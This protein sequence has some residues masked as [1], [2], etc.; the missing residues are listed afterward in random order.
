VF[1]SA[2]R[3]GFPRY[4]IDVLLDVVAL[5]SGIPNNMPGRCCDLSE[6]GLS[7][8]VAGELVAGQAVAIELR[9]PNVGLPV[10]ARAQVR[11]Q[12]R[13][14]CG[15]QFVGLSIEQREKIRYWTAQSGARLNPVEVRRVEIPTPELPVVATASESEKRQRK[16]RF[17]K[18]QFFLLLAVLATLGAVAWWQWQNAWSELEGEASASAETQPGQLLRVPSETMDRQITYKADPVYPDAARKTGTRG[19]VVLSVVIAP[20]GTV[21][22]AHQIAGPE[23]LAQSAVDAVRSW[24]Y[25]PFRVEGRPVKVETTVSVDFQLR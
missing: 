17:R 7:A 11:Y 13:L 2:S 1:H 12:E 20:D 22:R 18:R 24:K 3:R 6:T 16:L 4:P 8:I 14:R 19:L 9:L 25:A 23:V 10:R 21:E 5:Q 15:L